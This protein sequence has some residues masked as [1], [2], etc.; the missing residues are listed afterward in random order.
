[1]Y[2]DAADVE[3]RLHMHSEYNYQEYPCDA[4]SQ[5]NHYYPRHCEYEYGHG[6][7]YMPESMNELSMPMQSQMQTNR[8]TSIQTPYDFNTPSKFATILAPDNKSIWYRLKEI[9]EGK[10][11]ACNPTE[12]PDGLFCNCIKAVNDSPDTPDWN[13]NGWFMNGNGNRNRS[14]NGS[15][16]PSYKSY[17]ESSDC[18]Y[19]EAVVQHHYMSF[20]DVDVD[21]DVDV[22]QRSSS[23]HHSSKWNP[24]NGN[25]KTVKRKNSN[26]VSNRQSDIDHGNA[27]RLPRH[28]VSHELEHKLEHKHKHE[29]ELEQGY[30]L[31]NLGEVVN[32]SPE[33]FD[34]NQYQYDTF[35][36]YTPLNTERESRR[37]LFSVPGGLYASEDDSPDSIPPIESP[38]VSDQFV[39]SF[40]TNDVFEACTQMTVFTLMLFCG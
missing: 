8:Q 20:K 6:H 17:S 30:S 34:S 13:Q 27:Y 39:L 24:I 2:H 26:V 23:S 36:K 15:G 16:N 18:N 35:S 37:R 3:E 9:F 33:D 14:G 5:S 32:L 40:H 4:T 38:M 31:V 1:V 25:I 7:G 22:E 10:E 21:A 29:H 28:N 19:D 12:I 11:D